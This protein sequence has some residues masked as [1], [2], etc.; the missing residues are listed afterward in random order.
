MFNVFI[1]RI[2]E[3]VMLI[4]ISARRHILGPRGQTLQAV[5]LKTGARI[6]LPPRQESHIEEKSELDCDEDEEMMHVNWMVI[7]KAL[8]W[9]KSHCK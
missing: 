5:A 8:A 3:R 4:P 9:P 1:L 6:Q 2:N 7:R